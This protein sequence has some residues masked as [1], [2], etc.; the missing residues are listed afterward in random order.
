MSH[1]RKRC[2]VPRRRRPGAAQLDLELLEMRCL[3]DSGFRSITGFGNNPD[4][5]T[6]GMSGTDLLRVSPVAYAD[7]ISQ[8]SA[9]NGLSP[10]E[11][12]NNLSN[13]SDPIFSFADN[14][15]NPNAQRLSDYAYA[16]G[17]FIDHDMDLT[18]DNSGQ[19]FDILIDP[20]RQSGSNPDL[21]GVEPFTRS[22]FDPNTG[23]TTPRQQ[24][25]AVTSYLDLS[26]VYGS[27]QVVANAL[28]V[29]E[30][31]TSTGTPILGAH[32][33]TSPG[34]F[35]PLNNLS[36]FTQAQLN[37]LNMANDA[38]QVPNTSLFAAGDRRAN[39]NVEL[40]SLT[41][42]FLR[43]HNRLVDQLCSMNPASFGFTVWTDNNLYQEARKLNI[44]EAEM[45]T[46]NGYL[47]SI[48]GTNAIPGYTGY[49]GYVN[50]TIATEFSTVGFRFG[51]SLLSTT[52]GRDNND[53]TG[54]TDVNPNGSEINLTEDF[55]RPDLLNNN[56]VTVNL[57]DRFGNP[58]PHTSS[59]VGEVLKALADGLP[60][61]TDLLLIDEVR[62]VLF[63]IP[64]GP[65]TDLGA[66]DIQRA[67]DHGIG[68][69]N[70]VR[71]AYGL[72]AVT[73]Y[74]QISSDPAVQAALRGTYGTIN[75]HDNVNAVDPFIG[76]LAED[77]VRGGDVGPTVRA[78]L[79]K[80]FAALRDGD[81]FFFLN[82][83]FTSAEQSLL[84]QGNTLS[85]VIENNTSI[86]NLQSNAFFNR[87]SI[88]GNVLVNGVGLA[89]VVIQ[90][91]DSSGAVVATATTDSQGRY[92]FTEQTGIP[93]TGNYTVSIVVPAGYKPVSP[94]S[95]PVSLSRGDLDIDD[96]NFFLQ[97]S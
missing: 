10:R 36:Y 61:E 81:R 67:R 77:H 89:G 74:A 84:A 35:L 75:G 93:G 80:Q 94:A 15:G 20:T 30:G 96:I 18:L 21:M 79:V 39:E 54:I 25:N 7:G 47:P 92:H 58:D 28:R 55:F 38:Q 5:L 13:Q 78:I 29:V 31:F 87:L 83:S 1:A 44:A 34:D 82:E 76:M 88:S 22:Q 69:Y 37:A 64:H 23:T 3:L 91:K 65:G 73:S 51:H 26:Q 53:A 4:H 57:V 70:Q 32:L 68:T 62:N 14:N 63:G 52:V 48:L 24:I 85:E 42:L 86:T 71:V 40:L 59:T 56:H 60:N 66:R 2:P 11:I 16:W 9:P 46:Y 72:P 45:I 17:Q 49:K 12:S 97:K 90:L 95:I 19:S 41:T 33:K 6:W 50:A 43:N 27:T 8:P